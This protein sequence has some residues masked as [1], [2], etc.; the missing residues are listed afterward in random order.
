MGQEQEHAYPGR[1]SDIL[2]RSELAANLT[3]VRLIVFWL[4]L[5]ITLAAPSLSLAAPRTARVISIRSEH[6]SSDT[7]DTAMIAASRSLTVRIVL[8]GSGL[9]EISL[10]NRT[11]SNE[12]MAGQG[13]RFWRGEARAPS[14]ESG[15]GSSAAIRWAAASL[16]AG[17][18][19][20]ARGPLPLRDADRRVTLNFATSGLRGGTRFFALSAFD[21]DTHFRVVR[22]PHFAL[23][24]KGCG[25]DNLLSFTQATQKSALNGVSSPK[26]PRASLGKTLSIRSVADHLWIARYGSTANSR[27]ETITNAAASVYGRDVGIDI[28]V[29]STFLD[30]SPLSYPSA[31]TASETLLDLFRQNATRGAADVGVLFTDRTFDDGVIGIAYLGVVC[32]FPAASYGAIRRFQ[33]ALDPIILAHELGHNLSAEHVTEG[34][35]TTSLNPSNPPSSF[36]A[37]S[38]SQIS[39]HVNAYGFCLESKAST[40]TPQPTAT[41][42]ATRT[43]TPLASSTPTI[44]SPDPTTSPA[45]SPTTSPQQTP[46]TPSATPTPRSTLVVTAT[47]RPPETSFSVSGQV[48]TKGRRTAGVN[49]LVEGFEQSGIPFSSTVT[50]DPLGDFR[51]RGVPPGS[52]I[53]RLASP[54]LSSEPLQWQVIGTAGQRITALDFSVRPVGITMKRGALFTNNPVVPLSLFPPS[55][56]TKILVSNDGGFEEFTEF[57]VRS[58]LSWTLSSSGVERLPKTVYVRFAGTDIDSSQTFTDDII[59]DQT[60]PTVTRARG[61]K[62]TVLDEDVVFMCGKSRFSSKKKTYQIAARWIDLFRAKGYSLGPCSQDDTSTGADVGTSPGAARTANLSSADRL[63]RISVSLRARDATSGIDAVQFFN[64]KRVLTPWL[65]YKAAV[66]VVVPSDALLAVRVRDRAL[67]VSRAR[68]VTFQ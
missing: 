32:R 56:T 62:N 43:S 34:I 59:L 66:Q 65:P 42:T 16:T 38:V 24:D 6:G 7:I 36:S 51:L 26:T 47:P 15:R 9:T 58:T 60:Q 50:T 14:R 29:E 8:P 33:D 67:N 48:A 41:P 63:K 30:S 22:A 52:F 17:R 35:M 54:Q 20:L 68:K 25:S 3:G 46:P 10:N 49:I 28:S 40:P 44:P 53:V 21:G 45:P 61:S 27:I 19:S 23:A 39:S 5:F 37:A 18:R 11:L 1:C 31:I 64:G 55:G 4:L 2:G 12:Q 13:S 57:G